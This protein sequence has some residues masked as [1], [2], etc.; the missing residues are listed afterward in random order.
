MEYP[1]S[2][3]FGY[4]G[5]GRGVIAGAQD[6]FDDADLRFL[7]GDGLLAAHHVGIRRAAAIGSS[8]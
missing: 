6:R 2:N 8:A 7:C 3:C 5:W 1:C 4:T